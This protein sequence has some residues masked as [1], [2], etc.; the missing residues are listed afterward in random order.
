M[1]K[2]K[3]AETDGQ[4]K[5][6]RFWRKH[7]WAPYLPLPRS[8]N[9]TM[10]HRVAMGWIQNREQQLQVPFVPTAAW[11]DTI[12]QLRGKIDDQPL[13]KPPKAKKQKM[14]KPVK[15]LDKVP[16]GKAVRIQVYCTAEQTLLLKN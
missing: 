12:D 1:S 15:R 9:H 10:E 13:P 11:H 3:A 8:S 5:P 7:D 14:G 4:Y 2:R 6:Q 16:A